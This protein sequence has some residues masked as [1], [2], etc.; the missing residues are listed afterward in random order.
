MKIYH[1]IDDF[2][3]LDYA[4]VTSGTFD[5]VHVGHQ[6]IFAR[7][8]EATQRHWGE[9]VVL[10]FWPHP[11]LVLHPED[12]TLKLLNTFE[13]KAALLKDQGIN[14][15]IRI[16]FTKEFSQLS[17]EQFIRNILVDT[18][19]TKKLVIG[20]D[21]HFGKNREGSFEQLKQNGPLYGFEVEEIP[22]QDVDNIGVSSTKIRQALEEGDIETATHFLGKP[23][24]ITGR[25]VAGDKLGRLMGFPT[26]NIE[27]DTKFKLIPMDGIYAV[28]LLHEHSVYR[29]ML[30]IGNRPTINGTKK[31]IEVNIFD[32]AKE[33]YGESLTIYIHKLIRG[34]KKFSDLE[35][36][37]AQMK[38]DGDAALSILE[39]L[40]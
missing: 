3:K 25:V 22:R 19:G 20:Y 32:F 9:S 33:I 17:S 34:D 36:L 2:T 5:G 39:K 24:S 21:H 1:G 15:L 31:N 23:Y 8:R 38:K 26:A 29:G 35:T 16:P 40:K 18:I 27:V 12:D 7:I 37:K 4:I 13:E 10:T 6:K 30:Y 11:R 14:H 28:T